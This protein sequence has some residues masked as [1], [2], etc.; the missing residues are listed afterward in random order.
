MT[1]NYELLGKQL[2][3]LMASEPDILANSANFVGL[4][5]AEI[6]NINWLGLYIVRESDLVLGPYNGRPACVRI[7]MGQ[8]VCGRSA[9]DARTLRVADVD[10]FSGHI[11]CDPASKSE[12]VVPLIIDEVVIAVLDVDSPVYDRFSRQDQDGI[13]KLCRVFVARLRAL[14]A[15]HKNFI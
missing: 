9:S 4:L 13:E 11:R 15:R 5:F 1:V 12:I 7:P 10:Q 3:S 2:D 6:P 14:G 8:G